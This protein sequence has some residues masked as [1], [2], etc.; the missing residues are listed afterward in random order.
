VLP[1]RV[2]DLRAVGGQLVVLDDLRR[3]RLVRGVRVDRLGG[4]QLD[5]GALEVEERLDLGVV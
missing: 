1:H 5:V 2:G 3:Q 4:R